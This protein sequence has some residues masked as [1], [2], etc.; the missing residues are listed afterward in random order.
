LYNLT[1]SAVTRGSDSVYELYAELE[2]PLLRDLPF[3]K[4]LTI[5][6][7]GR[8][9]DYD[10][11]GDDT[12][13][14]IGLS[15]VATNWLS[16]RATYGTSYRAPAL[17]E[18][19]QGGT[20]G[21]L[22]QQGDPCNNW[23]GDPTSVR[24]INCA[25]EGLPPGFVATSSIRV[26]TSGGAAQGLAAETSDN[27]TAGIVLQPQLPDSWGTLAFAV[28]Y[29]DIQINNG[30]DR[31]GASNILSLCYDDPDFRTGGGYCRF[32]DPR[33][34]SSNALTVYDS[35][36]NIATQVVEGIDYNVRF[37]HEIGAGDLRMNLQITQYLSQKNRLFKVDPWDEVNGTVTNP[38]FTGEADIKYSWSNWA[39][40][41][42]LEWI[43]SMDSH[44]YLGLPS[45]KT[46]GYD[47]AVPDYFLHNVSVQY[48]SDNDW[49]TTLG[50]RNL[51]DE[52]PPWVSQGFYNRVGNSPLYSGY[53][54]VGREVFLNVSKKF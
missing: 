38:E 28:D 11:Y 14:K 19:F 7:S 5:N 25:A 53:D 13:Y 24:G 29:Y 39:V 50:V 52:T 15:Y 1:T 43:A 44:K 32:I 6:V 20:S 42:G 16:L 37:T 48:R 17:F 40:R 30:V 8:Y 51:L 46:S 35:Y 4:D 9:T 18:Q 21:F 36:T 49:E 2:V 54:Y 41:Y 34:P 45:G 27:L 12:T 23:D 31:V 26:I 10:S 3:V 47:F 33:D 22:S